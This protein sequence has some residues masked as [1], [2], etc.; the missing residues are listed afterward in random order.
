MQLTDVFKAFLQHLLFVECL[1]AFEL[2]LVFPSHFTRSE[3]FKSKYGI[4]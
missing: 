1:L 3:L 2:Q 4:C